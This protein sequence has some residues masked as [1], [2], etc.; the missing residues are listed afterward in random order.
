MPCT[1]LGVGADPQQGS[2]AAEY[3]DIA[4]GIVTA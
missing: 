1:L 3:E 2:I 4:M